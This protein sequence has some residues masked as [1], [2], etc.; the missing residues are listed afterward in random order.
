M[1]S[2]K[3]K[4]KHLVDLINGH[5]FKPEDWGLDGKPIIRIQNLNNADA[6]YNHTTKK[7]SDKYTV[8]QG[9]ILIAWSGSLGVY[10]WQEEEDALLNQHLFKVEFKTNEIDKGYFKYVV[11]Q[12]LLELSRKARGVGLKHLKKAQID[13]YEFLLPEKEVQKYATSVLNKIVHLIN[14]RKHVINLLDDYLSNSFLKSFLENPVFIKNQNYWGLIDDVVKKSIY[15]TSKKANE[16]KTG[17]PVLRMNNITHDGELDLTNI[18]WVELE[19]KDYNKYVLT[20]G[21]VLFNRTN[22][23]ELVGKTTVWDQGEG[24]TFAGYLVKI[25]LDNKIM[26]PY[27]FSSYLNSRFGKKILFNKGKTS[28]NQVNF[29][30]P[31]LKSQKILIPPIE[32]Q[33]N[34]DVLYKK[35]KAQKI[36]IKKSLQLLEE[37]HETYVYKT[38]SERKKS[39]DETDMLI[40]DFIKLELFLNTI[41]ASDYKSED[42]YDIDIRKL[43]NVLNRTEQLNEMDEN[44][45]KGIVQNLKGKNQVIIETTKEYKDRLN[46]EATQN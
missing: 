14:K 18:K 23:K 33:L 16:N 28:G 11:K 7:V 30:P 44:N 8:K 27:Y 24:F 9:D 39:Q 41:N 4:I 26:T 15:G 19:E 29:S 31:L 22:S 12:A 5:P 36:S 38:F 2:K 1:S 20:N 43:H 13:N 21:D 10:E 25:V 6:N 3:V 32:L 42:E 35:V 17:Y 37:L 45:R 34:Y 40:N 46:N